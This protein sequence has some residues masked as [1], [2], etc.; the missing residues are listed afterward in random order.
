M[1]RD[2]VRIHNLKFLCLLEA[3]VLASYAD[4]VW[5]LNT[6]KVFD[7]EEHCHNFG[8]SPLGRIWIKWDPS[9]VSFSPTFLSSQL[10]HGIISMGSLPPFQISVI[11]AANSFEERASLWNKIRD[12]IPSSPTPWMVMGDLNCYRFHNEKAGGNVLAS[13]RLQELNGTIFDCG[14]HEL[15]SVGLFYTWHNQRSD[16]PIHIKLDRVLVNSYFLD[17]FPLAH[18]KVTPPLCSDHS[19]LITNF[20]SSNRLP[21]RF[22]FKNYWTFMDGFWDDVLNS[23]L[24]PPVKGPICH[25]HQCLQNLK[26]A[27]RRREWASSNHLSNLTL[28]LKN[29]QHI[30]LEH[31]QNR[32]LDSSLNAALKEIN[33]NLAGLQA[34]WS[35]RV[36]QR[37]KAK[38]LSHG[39]DDLGF[40]YAK[41]RA[42]RNHNNLSEIADTHGTH[43]NPQDIAS[44]FIRHFKNLFN[45]YPLSH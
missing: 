32:P 39:E 15:A 14:L 36:S 2:L 28:E 17:H 37:A 13:G 10:I 1:C 5:F 20:S 16:Q 24:Q 23:F 19:P 25:L 35:S 41:I 11:Y 30:C 26:G 8:C 21:T 34:S 12:L 38:W 31:I 6:H 33:S 22:L 3:K 42:R 40:M 29:K 27:L 45:I 9:F 4:D 18:Y 44:A 7:N 43:S